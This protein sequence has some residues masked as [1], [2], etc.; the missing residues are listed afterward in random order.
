M[1]G[2]SRSS[3]LDTGLS[4]VS[5]ERA[6]CANTLGRPDV[7]TRYARWSVYIAVLSGHLTFIMPKKGSYLDILILSD[8]KREEL[9]VILVLSMKEV[10][11][12]EVECCLMQM[13]ASMQNCGRELIKL[14]LLDVGGFCLLPKQ[15]S[16]III[17]VIKKQ[18]CFLW[19]EWQMKA[20]V[21]VLN[22]K[23]WEK[24]KKPPEED[25]SRKEKNIEEKDKEYE[26]GAF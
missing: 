25:I 4:L 12:K 9:M 2:N 18:V 24:K 16:L 21:K 3:W 5:H 20:L 17:L 7:P 22:F 6:S 1:F 19:L 8:I 26:A 15:L 11:A 14:N 23:I 10:R 13:K